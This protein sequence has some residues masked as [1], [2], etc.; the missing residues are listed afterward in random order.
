MDHDTPLLKRAYNLGLKAVPN[1]TALT[2]EQIAYYE[3]HLGKIPDALLR[4][5]T[6]PDLTLL[7]TLDITVP[8]NYRHV[9]Q[10]ATFKRGHKKNCYSYSHAITDAN[11]AKATTVL[12]PGR[13]FKVKIW[14]QMVGG[15]T[16]SIERLAFLK[17]QKAVFTGAQGASLVFAQKRHALPKGYWYVSFD[18]K[19]A[20]FEYEEGYHG[21]PSVY[22]G[23]HGDF[24]FDLGPF[25]CDW[26]DAHCLLCFCEE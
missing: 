2:I 25:E 15:M 23:S 16:T 5:F 26:R 19:D 24:H 14:K 7:T 8:A 17:S 11:F 1:F 12:T 20:L 9:T 18:E 6:G 13:K 21:V 22:A 3:Q 4:G 10:L